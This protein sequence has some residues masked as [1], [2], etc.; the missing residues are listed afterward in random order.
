MPPPASRHTLPHSHLIWDWN[1]TLL[2]DLDYS[3]DVMN[4]LLARRSLPLLDRPRYH[5]LFDFPVRNY[6][7]RLGFDPVADPF[8][9]LSTEFITAYDARRT[10][11]ALHREADRV[12]AAVRRSGLGQSILSAYRH[13]T[14]HEIVAHFGLTAHFDHIAGLDNI[15]AHSKVALGRTLV[16][17][18]GVPPAQILLI[19]DTLHDYEVA[20]ELGVPCALIAAGH[21]PAGRLGA[22]GATVFPSLADFAAAHGL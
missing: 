7:A 3:I 2:D 11:T 18:L 12:L 15:H 13:E 8:E 1:G 4:A 21:H 17:R 10:E 20:R 16:T 22:S 9:K 6:Y 19:G 14:L 5:A